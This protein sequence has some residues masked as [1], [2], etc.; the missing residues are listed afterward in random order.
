VARV[1]SSSSDRLFS[2]ALL[3]PR[4]AGLGLSTKVM[5]GLER[6]LPIVTTPHGA[7]G[8]NVTQQGGA[9]V[10]SSRTR[11]RLTLQ[12]RGCCLPQPQSTRSLLGMS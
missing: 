11:R 3:S 5:L 10:A 4:L 1:S 7:T 2:V 9:Q 8:Y 6:G 12:G